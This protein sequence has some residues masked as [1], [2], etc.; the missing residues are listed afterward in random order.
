M[1]RRFKSVLKDNK[2]ISMR[3]IIDLPWQFPSH[4]FQFLID[5]YEIYKELGVVGISMGGD[6]FYARPK[7]VAKIFR[8][9][10]KVGLKLLCHAGETTENKFAIDM[11]KELKP[12]RI[13]HGISIADWLIHEGHKYA[14]IDTC[15]T[16]NLKIGIV[17]DIKRHP[18]RK[19]LENNITFTLS[20]DDPA[21]FNTTLNDEYK[22]AE[23]SFDQF[24][25][26]ID[27]YMNYTI[28]AA[29]DK[30]AA[31]NILNNDK[32]EN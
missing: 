22:L 23:E 19:W 7:E 32:T 1:L 2:N 10:R 5:E 6:E 9:A 27:N 29:F 17:K 14:I 3:F 24:E 11:I 16:S 18:M 4:S 25:K 20:T 31:Q 13:A 15:L 26:Y 30:E 28:E 21:I 12:D 8:S